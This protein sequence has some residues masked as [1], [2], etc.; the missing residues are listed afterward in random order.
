MAFHVTTHI[1][2][3]CDTDKLGHVNNAIY[4]VMI[5]A[6]RADM[7]GN[8]ALLAVDQGHS[9]V[10]VRLEIDFIREMS[11]PGEVR[12]ES[13][14]TKIGNKSFQLR[15]RLIQNGEVAGRGL[16]ILAVM[17]MKTRRAVPILPAWHSE[18][19]SYLDPDF[20]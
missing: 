8:T 14:V 7:L 6:G 9:P 16:A 12:V 4:A 19:S 15:H 11:W 17:D 1:L 20:T 2:R 13:A 18:L 3:F 5:E 10:I